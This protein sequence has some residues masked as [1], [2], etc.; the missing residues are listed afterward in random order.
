[1]NSAEFWN[2][3]INWAAIAAAVVVVLWLISSILKFWWNFK[4]SLELV[5]LR[6]LIPKKDSKEDK[7]GD[8]E[9]EQFGSGKEFKKITGIMVHFLENLQ[10]MFSRKIKSRFIGQNF[11]SLEYAMLE[12]ELNFFMVV[13]R[14]Y[15]ELV[16]KQITGF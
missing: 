1:M 14:A 4:R 8:S 16:E 11:F 5:F 2:L 7:G 13:P 10:I 9:H 3:V 15:K 6:I 12:G